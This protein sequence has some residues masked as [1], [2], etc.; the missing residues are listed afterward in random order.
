MKLHLEKEQR[1]KISILELA[2]H[3]RRYLK[4]FLEKY[5]AGSSRHQFETG[6]ETFSLPSLQEQICP[7]NKVGYDVKDRNFSQK[8]YEAIALL[9]QQ[10]WLIDVAP[11]SPNDW[12]RVQLTSK[13]ETANFNNEIS[14]QIDDAQEV[15]SSLKEKTPNLDSIVEQYYLESLQTCGLGFYISSVLCL[16][17]ASERAI[18]C[19]ADAVIV[20][21]DRYQKDINSKKRHISELTRYLSKT[22][23]LISVAMEGSFLLPDLGGKLEGLANIYR[24]NRNEAGHPKLLQDWQKSEQESHLKAFDRYIQTVFKAIEF[25][26]NEKQNKAEKS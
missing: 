16:G 24:I 2:S 4:F 15:I 6:V 8:F 11:T 26:E 9:K 17:I 23:K 22:V 25:L 3:I 1:E 21:N 13:G 12:P 5:R 14:I 19:L 7:E 20:H 10:R 18:L